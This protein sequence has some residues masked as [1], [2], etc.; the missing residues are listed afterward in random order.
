MPRAPTNLFLA[1]SLSPSLSL[2]ILDINASIREEKER[3][4]PAGCTGWLVD[5]VDRSLLSLKGSIFAAFHAR[6]CSLLKWQGQEESTMMA[7]KIV[8]E[9]KSSARSRFS[10]SLSSLFSLDHWTFDSPIYSII[11][12]ESWYARRSN[13]RILSRVYREGVHH[14]QIYKHCPKNTAILSQ[15]L[16]GFCRLHDFFLSLVKLFI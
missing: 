2:R 7:T 3:T 10:L 9:E 12:R 16:F 14:F 13:V 6:L 4:M 11:N 15:I 1:A 8:Y 5:I